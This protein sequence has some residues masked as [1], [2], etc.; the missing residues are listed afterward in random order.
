MKFIESYKAVSVNIYKQFESENNRKIEN[1]VERIVEK[2]S[3]KRV[4]LV[5]ESLNIK[6]QMPWP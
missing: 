3:K 2:K 6:G 1:F 4:K 5:I